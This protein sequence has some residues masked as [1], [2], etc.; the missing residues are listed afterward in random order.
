MADNE[1]RSGLLVQRDPGLYVQIVFVGYWKDSVAEVLEDDRE[2]MQHRECPKR[3]YPTLPGR[4]WMKFLCWSYVGAIM[5]VG[6]YVL[7][8]DSVIGKTLGAILLD[9]YHLLP[10][11][12]R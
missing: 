2:Q 12:C 8:E 11:P 6:W 3:S 1:L 4:H 9:R 10:P 7:R 5:V